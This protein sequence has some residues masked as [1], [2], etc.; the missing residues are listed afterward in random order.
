MPLFQY[1]LISAFH[2]LTFMYLLL[3]PEQL[4]VVG[5]TPCV[6]Y[7]QLDPFFHKS[8]LCC[9]RRDSAEEGELAAAQS[10][11]ELPCGTLTWL[12]IQESISIGFIGLRK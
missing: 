10:A 5:V 8:S 11:S 9:A 4:M 3:F 12:K 2:F 7:F 1:L 6:L